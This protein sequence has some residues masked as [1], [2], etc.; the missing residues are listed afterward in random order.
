MLKLQQ[1]TEIKLSLEIDS[2]LLIL[3]TAKLILTLTQLGINTEGKSDI[4]L[5][6][7]KL[8]RWIRKAYEDIMEDV[9]KEPEERKKVLQNLL[10]F[11]EKFEGNN[12]G[13]GQDSNSREQQENNAQNSQ[14]QS[15]FRQDV[16]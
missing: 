15:Q 7:R 9:N 13:V 4:A 8:I 11:V 3:R 12:T 14:Q 16:T 2:C 10:L 5:S 6:K 1:P